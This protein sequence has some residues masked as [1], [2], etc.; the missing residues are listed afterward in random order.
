MFQFR[1]INGSVFLICSS[2]PGYFQVIDEP[3]DMNTIENKIKCEKYQSIESLDEDFNN[4]FHSIEVLIII[5]FSG[6]PPNRSI[7]MLMD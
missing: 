7:T 6:K 3:I 2:E 4:L 1:V 5:F